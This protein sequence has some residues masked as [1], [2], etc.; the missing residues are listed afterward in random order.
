[1]VYAGDVGVGVGDGVVESRE[2]VTFVGEL[3]EGADGE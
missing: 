3:G 1:M 2:E